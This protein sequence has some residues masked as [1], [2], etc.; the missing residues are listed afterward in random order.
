ML[1]VV[2]SSCVLGM[3]SGFLVRVF[4]SFFSAPKTFGSISRLEEFGFN[5]GAYFQNV[6]FPID[7]FRYYVR[8]IDL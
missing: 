3:G 5:F 7:F 6:F 4:R 2:Y 8:V 1:S